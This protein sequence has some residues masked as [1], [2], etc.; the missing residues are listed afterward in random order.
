MAMTHII[1]ETRLARLVF[2]FLACWLHHC[3]YIDAG[4]TFWTETCAPLV[5]VACRWMASTASSDC[6][7]STVALCPLRE[8][9]IHSGWSTSF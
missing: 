3:M 5:N 4:T 9:G 6:V 8:L 2:S 7:R 1:M